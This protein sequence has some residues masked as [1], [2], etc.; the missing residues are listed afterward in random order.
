MSVLD[1]AATDGSFVLTEYEAKR[2]VAEYG[3]P[4]PDGDLATTT[5]EAVEIA[6][7]LGYPVAMKAMAREI[8]HKSDA[9]IISLDVDSAAAVE[10][11]WDDLLANA[12]EYD[13]D[14]TVDGVL[15]TPMAPPGI[16][17]IVGV[18]RDPQFGPVVMFGLGGIFVEVLEDV[19]L[20]VA[21][22]DALTAEEM[23][24]EIDGHPLLQGARGA[25]PVDIDALCDVIVAVSE[26]AMDLPVEE[27]DLNPVFAY[28]D[29][30]L[31]IDASMVVREWPTSVLSSPP[32]E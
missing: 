14:A 15:V 10:E 24:A 22:I 28:P 17:V 29:G 30:A 8:V 18:N 7:A 4:V 6:D 9:G 20:R 16:E 19:S 31:A 25:D 1:G 23:I 3:V 5:A 27:L 26:L 21:P 13:P 11:A 12:T 32:P 2:V